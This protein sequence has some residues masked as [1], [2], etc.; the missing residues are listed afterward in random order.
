MHDDVK[1][2]FPQLA[3]ASSSFIPPYQKLGQ[4]SKKQKSYGQKTL[5]KGKV[6]GLLVMFMFKYMGCEIIGH[7]T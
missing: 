5:K 6:P 3:C 2:F 7:M 1:K 4:N